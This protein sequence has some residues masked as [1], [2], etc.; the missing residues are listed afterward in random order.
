M[1]E[2]MHTSFWLFLVLGVLGFWSRFRSTLA[3]PIEANY[4]NSH[5]PLVDSIRPGEPS[6]LETDIFRCRS[7]LRDEKTMKVSWEC[8]T[9][10]PNVIWRPNKRA[11]ED[12]GR[13]VISFT[14]ALGTLYSVPY[15][16]KKLL[17]LCTSTSIDIF[18]EFS[19]AG[20]A[21]LPRDFTFIKINE[22]ISY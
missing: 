11:L 17:N 4:W 19:E 8:M 21:T 10:V 5:F 14:D 2:G 9:K 7:S 22:C 3:G 13:F 1:G 16:P 6:L 20:V 15:S 12:K 18:G